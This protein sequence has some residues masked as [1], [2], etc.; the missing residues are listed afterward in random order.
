MRMCN[1]IPVLG[2]SGKL[3]PKLGEGDRQVPEGIHRVESLNPN[4][5]Y[6]LALRVGYPNEEDRKHAAQEGRTNLGSDIMIH[7]KNS[8][9]G[10]PQDRPSLPSWSDEL[11]ATVRTELEKL[12]R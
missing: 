4:S 2:M 7:G 9:I 11:Y 3:G 10:C 1:S 5:L 6:H 8:S 12:Q